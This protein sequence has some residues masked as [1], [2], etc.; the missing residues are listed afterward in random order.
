MLSMGRNGAWRVRAALGL[1]AAVLAACGGGQAGGDRPTERPAISSTEPLGGTDVTAD[2]LMNWAEQRYPQ[3][4]WPA[5]PA[6]QELAPYLYRLYAGSGNALG[7]DGDR[8]HVYGPMSDFQ[9][10]FVGTV[11]QFACEAKLAAC[12]PPTLLSWP[13]SAEILRGRPVE[14]DVRV[15]GGPSL[16]YQWLRDGVPIPGA[17]TARLS[18]QAVATEDNGVPYTLRV[19]N[20]QGT[21]VTPPTV[22]TVIPPVPEAAFVAAMQAGGCRNCH[23][24]RNRLA[25]PAMDEIGRKYEARVDAHTYLVGR[26]LN[27][28]SGNWGSSMPPNPVSNELAVILASGILTLK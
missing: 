18:L 14:F 20:A 26:I 9:T 4:F 1:A 22:L 28:S 24:V 25:G 17:E 21:A 19:T 7:L 23:D 3:Y 16:R 15:G 8:V 11:E 2:D 10:L 27:G 5:R 6:N 13:P 12:A